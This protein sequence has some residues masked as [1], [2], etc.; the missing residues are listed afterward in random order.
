[1]LEHIDITAAKNL[2]RGK[3]MGVYLK[4]MLVCLL[5]VTLT[6]GCFTSAAVAEAAVGGIKT[7]ASGGG[8]L[9]APA[10]IAEMKA[11][12]KK[13]AE[14][15][16]AKEAKAKEQQAS[17]AAKSSAKKN[18]NKRA[19]KI[20]AEYEAALAKTYST[21]IIADDKYVIMSV[22]Q[23]Y[24][25]APKDYEIKSCKSLNKKVATVTK[26]GEITAVAGGSTAIV[27]TGKDG[28]KRDFA[29]A[30][31]TSENRSN[32]N[33]RD[34]KTKAVFTEKK[35]FEELAPTTTMTFE[36]L[37]WDDGD[38]SYPEGFLAPDA[39]KII[40]DCYYQVVM[41]FAKDEL[42]NYTI[43]VRYMICSTGASDGHETRKGTFQL[44]SAR[45]RYSIFSGT[46]S[47]AQYWSLIVSRTYFH[48]ML[49]N[50]TDWTDYTT[51]SWKNLGTNVSHGCVR[52]TVPDARWI[53]YNA[54]PGTTV[55]IRKG[56]A[57][58]KITKAIRKQLVLPSAPKERPSR[59][60]EVTYGDNWTKESIDHEVGFVQGWQ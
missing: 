28:V 4:K 40:V 30:V 34:V 44:K 37:V 32:I 3:I 10:N 11:K 18:S 16:A 20:E 24:R 48:S 13:E 26:S 7:G 56:S 31:K 1:M 46:A 38:Y 23:T 8:E 57:D 50:S 42:G 12:E 52:L 5:A 35:S 43:P 36:Q 59:D 41:V 53:W 51:S 49:Y 39:Y 27:I 9:T 55:E 60:M 54:A 6:A 25:I 29:V 2:R 47:Y 45:V 19:D 58:D 33:F 17:T 21:D 22:G 14:E 15:K